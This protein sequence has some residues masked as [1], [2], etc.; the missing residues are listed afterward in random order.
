MQILHCN[1]AEDFFH[2]AD[3][4]SI[5]SDRAVTP[6]GLGDIRH[7]MAR[8]F[9][10]KDPDADVRRSWIQSLDPGRENN[11]WLLQMRCAHTCSEGK[12]VL[13]NQPITQA[14]TEDGRTMTM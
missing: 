1:Q 10:S 2:W 5:I 4:L 7:M 3:G 11:A 14:E 9:G 8:E 13:V 12:E 6:N